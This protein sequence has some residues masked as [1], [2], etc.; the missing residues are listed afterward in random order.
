MIQI[1]KQLIPEEVCNLLIEEGLNRP[2]LNAGIGEDN[3]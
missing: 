3:L 1:F 2:Q